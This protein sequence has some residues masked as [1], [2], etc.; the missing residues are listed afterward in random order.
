MA[1]EVIPVN[2]TMPSSNEENADSSLETSGI[3]THASK[4]ELDDI[5]C[6]FGLPEVVGSRWPNFSQATRSGP[7][8]V[9]F[10]IAIAVLC[11]A[12]NRRSKA[13]SKAQQ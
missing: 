12:E 7:W 3:A 11:Y 4:R 1:L 13:K 6:V 9:L 5:R 2:L 10:F 8:P